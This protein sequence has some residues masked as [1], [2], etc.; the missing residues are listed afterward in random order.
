M[1]P[2]EG[3]A[4][5]AGL[6]GISGI[7]GVFSPKTLREVLKVIQK[8]SDSFML[9]FGLIAFMGAMFALLT[10]VMLS[11]VGLLELVAGFLGFIFLLM[12][13]LCL[14][15][16][17]PK[18]LAKEYQKLPDVYLQV[19]AGLDFLIGLAIVYLALA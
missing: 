5:I 8:Q 9:L 16:S 19:L 4:L 12:A 7:I 10:I 14:T 18:A 1:T 15:P 3:I 17:V 6:L 11:S 2:I 13:L